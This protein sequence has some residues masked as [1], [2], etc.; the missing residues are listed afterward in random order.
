MQLPAS[1]STRSSFLPVRN[2]L[3]PT[4]TVVICT[5][6]RPAYLR[7]CLEAVARLEP[8]AN[9]VIVVDNSVGDGETEIVAR[10]FSVRYTIEPIVGLSRARNRGLRESS[11][12]IIAYVD[13]DAAPDERWL[14]L[15]IEQFADPTVAVVTGKTIS[16]DSGLGEDW[17]P[18]RGLSNKDPKWFEIATFGGLGIG[19]N[20][21][22]RKAACT[23]RKV[24]DERLGRGAPFQVGEEDYAFARFLSLGYR[25]VHT[26]AALVVHPFK[27]GNVEQEA[28]Q[29]IAYW[30]LLF[31]E[32]PG[33]RLD[34][35]QFL[36]R[37]LR[38]KPLT[39][40]RSSPVLGPIITSGWRARV[41]ATLAGIRLYFR[42]RRSN[43]K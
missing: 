18:A 5:R 40:Q 3:E 14:G 26:P 13:D 31:F 9:E 30:F 10:E 21:A 12:E 25:A 22:I 28:S 39:W 6:H 1:G 41:K 42:A 37:R 17:G 33:H 24:F 35:V 43:S 11:S 20:M 15:L 23:G 27:A 4:A 7:K 19:A 34:L 2:D 29:A 16:L 38:H 32:F 36:F 8:P